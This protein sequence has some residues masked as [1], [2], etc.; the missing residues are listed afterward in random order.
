MTL[1]LPG[2]DDWLDLDCAS[3]K[4]AQTQTVNETPEKGYLQVWWRK[5]LRMRP[6]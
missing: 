2:L 3:P 4:D 6:Y 1:D 5:D